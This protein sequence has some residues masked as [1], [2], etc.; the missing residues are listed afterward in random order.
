MSHHHAVKRITMAPLQLLDLRRFLDSLER[1]LLA[2][3]SIFFQV[4]LPEPR[5]DCS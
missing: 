2:S 5:L 4:E 1:F 3:D